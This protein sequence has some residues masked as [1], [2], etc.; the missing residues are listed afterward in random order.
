MKKITLFAIAVCAGGL[1]TTVSAQ[2]AIDAYSLSQGDLR[3]TARF[4]SMAGAFG[5][6]GGDLSTLNQNPAG[7]GVYRSSEI[8]VTVDFDMQSMKTD[9]FYKDNHTHVYCNNFGYVGSAFTG[10]DI[11]PVFTWGA[12]YT[13]AASFDRDYHGSF[14]SLPTSLSNY[15]ASFTD[16]VAPGDLL[17][18]KN[19]NP[20]Q[21]VNGV[22][23]DWLSILS[24]NS[25]LINP[26][27]PTS[28]RYN[29]LF[30]NGTT[31]N[32]EYMVRE[33]GSIDEYSVNF[34]GNFINK[35]YWGI[36]I[37][38]TDIRYSRQVFYD[39]ELQGARIPNAEATGTETGNGYFGLDNFKRITGNGYNFKAGVIVKPI[40]ELR[41]GLAFHTP[42]YY[43]LNQN[44]DAVVDYSY[45]SGYEGSSD[46]D[47]G[48]FEYRLRT[49]WKMIASV[50]G[51]IGGR[52][53]LSFD[54]Q[55]DAYNSMSLSDGSNGFNYDYVNNNVKNYYKASNTYRFGAELCLTPQFSL[56]AGYSYQ[57][58]GV[59]SEAEDQYIEVETSG[60]DPS[61]T[62]DNSTQY[63]TV[64]LGYRYKAFYADLAYVHRYRQSTFHPFTAWGDSPNIPTS[65]LSQRDNNIVVTLGVKF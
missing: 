62:F 54:Y 8:G 43:S 6:L 11:M 41:F 21:G 38:I 14:S 12:T 15:V 25:Y 34:G 53:I 7:I 17:I 2:S 58:G 26:Q 9:N 56:R 29:G 31:G 37:G 47:L 52:A 4:M 1:V 10:S 35:I 18:D 19:Q 16:G 28:T 59:K 24:Y 49:P 45:E 39:E 30:Q 42:T 65:K 48:Y 23:P 13:R 63:G 22:Y 3:G 32:S 55:R 46:T 20:Y 40:D 5:A 61:Y 44:Y 57:N 60:T 51:V 50:A 33:R 27:T 36:G 64:G